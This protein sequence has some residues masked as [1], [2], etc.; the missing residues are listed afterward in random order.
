MDN[1]QQQP[2][3]RLTRSGLVGMAVVLIGLGILYWCGQPAD[4]GYGADPCVYLAGAQSL[5][6]GHGYRFVTHALTPPIC[7]VPPLQSA[8]LSAWWR[9]EPSFPANT[10]WLVLGM[11]VLALAAL[12]GFGMYAVRR[13]TPAPVVWLLMCLWGG[14]V[15]WCSLIYSLL[16]DILFVC[17]W[18]GAAAVWTVDGDGPRSSP[19][20]W[21]L[22]GVCGAGA[23]LTRTAALAPLLVLAAVVLWNV[24][25]WGWKPLAAYLA[26][27]VLTV[28]GWRWL[29]RGNLNYGD[30]F[31]ISVETADGAWGLVRGLLSNVMGY[32]SGIV[33]VRSL[34][35]PLSELPARLYASHATSAE[36]LDA[37]L[38][39]LSWLFTALWLIGCW[40]QRRGIDGVVALAVIGYLMELA[41]WPFDLGYRG[42]YPVLPFVLVWA[43]QGLRWAVGRWPRAQGLTWA[44]AV[45]IV[46]NGLVNLYSLRA[47]RAEWALH[48]ALPELREICEWINAHTPADAV[49]AATWV[50]PTMHL[51]HYTGRRVVRNYWLNV[52]AWDPV[53]HASQNFIPADYVL[54]SKHT[55]LRTSAENRARLRLV[56]ASSQFAYSVYQVDEPAAELTSRT[57]RSQPGR[58]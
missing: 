23:Y 10:P 5:A 3:Q 55:P 39:G 25:R 52:P 34:C 18:L 6:E 20:R 31:Q 50:E 26:P 28:A 7:I 2:Q 45:V 57:S 14:S 51:Y 35:Q 19:A 38:V 29:A 30:C 42:I 37:L 9:L 40:R 41:L 24:R 27:V 36:T 11:I 33:F 17:F 54:A 47:K 43:W 15:V 49:I 8:Y 21:W 1:V 16:S 4:V 32:Q 56:K 48:T 53:A 13:G 44:L 58:P 46:A 12:G 22:T